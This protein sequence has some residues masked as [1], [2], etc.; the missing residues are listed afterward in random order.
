MASVKRMTTGDWEI[1]RKKWESDDRKGYKWIV[2]E[3]ELS[4]SD[5][6]VLKR[7]KKENWTKKSTT[8]KSGDTVKSREKVS[9]K[10]SRK[11][12]LSELTNQYDDELELTESGRENKGRPP[13]GYVP[14]YAE[15]V[16]ELCLLG[17]TDEEIAPVFGI[18]V[19]TLNRWKDIYPEFWQSM[20]SG[21]LVADA[22][23]ASSTYLSAI[24]GHFIEEER[25]VSGGNGGTEII[26]IK[27]QVPPSYQAQSLWLRNRR[28]ANWK[29]KVELSATF[30]VDKE[31]L[32]LIESDGMKRLEESRARQNAVLTE[33]GIVIDGEFGV[34]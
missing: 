13:V 16:K 30:A 19:R 9:R 32:D 12:S 5:V 28:P 22:K 15:Q 31:L 17:L 1:V 21:K 18:S 10:V 29:E 23:V 24:G 26:T 3:M 7:A 20:C 8:K 27:K 33:R 34:I 11:V 6:A 2:D 14:L 4:I 25:P